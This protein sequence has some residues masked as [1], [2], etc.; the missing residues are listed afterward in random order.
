MCKSRVEKIDFYSR[1]LE[2][3]MSMQ[4]Y[5]PADYSKSGRL[6]VLYF[7]HGRSGDENVILETEI[8]VK[9]DKLIENGI[10]APMII[11]CP[12]MEN[13]LGINSLETS[14]EIL[15]PLGNGR[16]IYRGRYEDYF[17]EEVIPLTDNT[18]K[19]IRNREGRYIGGVSAGGYAALHNAFRHLYMFSKAGGHM[20][21]LE[22]EPDDE[23]AYFY[24]DM[25]AWKKYNPI[26]IVKNNDMHSDIKVYLDAGD[27]DEGRFYEGC[28]I[29][30][31]LL[32]QKGISVKY[33]L[34]SGNHSIEYIK[35]N[36]E[37]YLKFYGVR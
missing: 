30:Y 32:K 23:Y 31:E 9:A 16:T 29:L 26:Y 15:N 25:T 19:T 20:P 3:H 24:E 36:M 22:L 2:K 8:N 35:N 21:A 13:S 5:I 18:F 6:P 34:F 7:L 11:V 27:K 17:I 4:V 1:I 28:S 12:R 33:Y 10:I 37:N 14:S